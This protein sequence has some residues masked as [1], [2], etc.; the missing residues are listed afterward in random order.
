[1]AESDEKENEYYLGLLSFIIGPATTTLQLFF[2]M[3]VLKSLDF[4]IFLEKH[5]HILFHELHPFTPCCHCQNFSTGSAHRKGLLTKDQFDVLFE[6]DESSEMQS[7]K[8]TQGQKLKEPLCLC[9]VSAKLTTT[10]DMID[11][12][13]LSALIKSCCPP[14]T[15]PG[16]SLKWI[17]DIKQAIN[18]IVHCSSKK[19]TKLEYDERFS[20]TE[21]AVSDLAGVVD[22]FMQKM[23]KIQISQ[24]KIS[25]LSKDTKKNNNE[26]IRRVS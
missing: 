11:I 7:H 13:L 22:P 1:M 20:I 16:G 19:M 2:E 6:T 24:Y 25:E 12:A 10:V 17:K 3:K 26:S 21:Q 14:E 9:G 18:Y 4:F 8:R 23:V 15:I 5:K